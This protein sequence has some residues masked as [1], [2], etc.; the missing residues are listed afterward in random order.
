MY[1]LCTENE[2]EDARGKKIPIKGGSLIEVLAND[3]RDVPMFHNDPPGT[4]TDMKGLTPTNMVAG[5]KDMNALLDTGRW[6]KA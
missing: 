1:K 3:V 4:G 6:G 5:V 2:I